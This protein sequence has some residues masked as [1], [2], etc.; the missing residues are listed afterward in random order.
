MLNLIQ[1]YATEAIASL[2][3]IVSVE[4]SWRVNRAERRIDAAQSA[5]RRT[6]MLVEV[7]LKNAAVGKLAL[8][9]SRKLLLIQK[10]PALA[11]LTISESGRLTNNLE[12][13]QEF[14]ASEETQRKIAEEAG[15]GGSID[16]YYQ[17]FADV[18]RLRVS[19]E[20]EIE[21][22]ISV[23]ESLADQASRSGA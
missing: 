22:E 8:I 13:M 7:E 15:G 1:Q 16:H 10:N 17:A 20:A 5:A 3:L 19:L 4:A 2:A 14:K 12:L 11:S 18:K 6:D 9:C 23:Y 21:K